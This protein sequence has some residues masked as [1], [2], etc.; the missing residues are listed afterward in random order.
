MCK[1][2]YH[3]K[4]STSPTYIYAYTSPYFVEIIVSSVSIKLKG[5]GAL[6]SSCLSVRSPPVCGHNCFRSVSSTILAGSIWFYTSYQPL[7]VC[8]AWSTFKYFTIYIPAEYSTSWLSVWCA[9]VLF[10]KLTFKFQ[11]QFFQIAVFQEWIWSYSFEFLN[12]KATNGGMWKNSLYVY[13]H[14]E[15]VS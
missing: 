15:G 9:G 10:I 13:F 12:T 5:W 2:V 8:R 14:Q 7:K 6:V 3:F 1:L 4:K 11:V